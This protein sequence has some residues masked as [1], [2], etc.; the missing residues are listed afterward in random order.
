M[1]VGAGMG[2]VLKLWIR[3]V[4]VGFKW[5]ESGVGVDDGAGVRWVLRLKPVLNIRTVFRN[6]VLEWCARTVFPNTFKAGL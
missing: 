2:R 5:D 3:W 6:I 4:G 1:D